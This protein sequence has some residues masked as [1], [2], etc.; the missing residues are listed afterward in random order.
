MF[1][2]WLINC[3]NN[4]GASQDPNLIYANDYI[5]INRKINITITR[6]YNDN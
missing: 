3:P 5:K 2:L 4:R 1:A 6:N